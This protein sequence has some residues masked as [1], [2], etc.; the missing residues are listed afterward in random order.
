MTPLAD[1]FGV[2]TEIL[3][4][5]G[6]RPIVSGMLAAACTS[7]TAEMQ[8]APA[9]VPQL[10]AAPRGLDEES[11]AVVPAPGA[12][13]V[14]QS[15]LFWTTA[16]LSMAVAGVWRVQPGTT[17]GFVPPPSGCC[18][19]AEFV[20][21]TSLLGNNLL[22]ILFG[23]PMFAYLL[24]RSKQ[25]TSV[26][27]YRGKEGPTGPTAASESTTCV[28]TSRPKPIPRIENQRLSTEN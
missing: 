11:G 7:A 2:A 10:A 18:S 16:W 17:S 3:E 26:A 27:K 6:A 4:G 13:G 21:R 14:G 8:S 24:R 25:A 12:P 23:V 1:H 9:Y 5:C 15:L 22:A 20:R 28:K 19:T